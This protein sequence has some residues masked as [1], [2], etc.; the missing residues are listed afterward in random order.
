MKYGFCL[1]P[2]YYFVLQQALNRLFS[3]ASQGF[4]EIRVAGR[5]T[6]D[7]CRAAAKVVF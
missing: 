2:Y 4:F 6:S 3:F 5:F 7:L 1:L